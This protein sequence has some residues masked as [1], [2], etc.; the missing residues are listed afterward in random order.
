MYIFFMGTLDR[1]IVKCYEYSK[2]SGRNTQVEKFMNII[3]MN[4]D[5]DDF[6]ALDRNDSPCLCF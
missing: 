6:F 3:N 4:I 1:C 2:M 5:A